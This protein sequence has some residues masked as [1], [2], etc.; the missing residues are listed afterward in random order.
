[1]NKILS[2]NIKVVFTVVKMIPINVNGL[3]RLGSAGFAEI[4]FEKVFG[5]GI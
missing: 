1:M 5:I 3:A 4:F 2:Y